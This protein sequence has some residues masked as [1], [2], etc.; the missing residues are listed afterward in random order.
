MPNQEKPISGKFGSLTV[1]NPNSNKKGFCR[2]QCDCGSASFE[3]R[4]SSLRSGNTSSCGCKRRQNP[5][6]KPALLKPSAYRANMA[7]IQPF[8]S[9]AEF[10]G[11]FGEQIAAMKQWLKN[12]TQGQGNAI[13]F[14]GKNFF[15]A[16]KGFESADAVQAVIDA[17]RFCVQPDPQEIEKAKLVAAA[18]NADRSPMAL[19]QLASRLAGMEKQ[20]SKAQETTPEPEPDEKELVT[21]PEHIPPQRTPEQVAAQQEEIEQLKKMVADWDE[22]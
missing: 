11:Q 12:R 20:I 17:I 21:E 22:D 4:K 19:Q 7:D 15:V 13:T 8:I 2:V 6:R 3:V 9:F 18:K 10:G 1:T 16:G 5:G 14:N